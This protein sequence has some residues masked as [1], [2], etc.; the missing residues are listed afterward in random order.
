MCIAEDVKT[1]AREAQ[2][3]SAGSENGQRRCATVWIVVT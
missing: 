3:E 1:K 2:S